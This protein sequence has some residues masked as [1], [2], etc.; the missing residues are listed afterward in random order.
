MTSPS[1]SQNFDESGTECKKYDRIANLVNERRRFSLDFEIIL[2]FCRALTI[3][4][5]IGCGHCFASEA[6]ALLKSGERCSS[7]G[8]T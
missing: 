8:N 7:Y 3:E 2:K 6:F 4:T 5:K 1:N